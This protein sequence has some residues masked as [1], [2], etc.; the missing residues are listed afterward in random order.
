LG[1]LLYEMLKGIPVHSSKN[2]RDSEV[3]EAVRT[4][5]PKPMTRPDL[6]EAIKASVERAIARRPAERYTGVV[7]IGRDLRSQFGRVPPEK[8]ETST[9]RRVYIGLTA[10]SFA[11]SLMILLL[12]LFT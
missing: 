9:R 2:R 1:I 11:F 10:A 7:E 4:H 12:A 8:K 3:R 6:P 5:R